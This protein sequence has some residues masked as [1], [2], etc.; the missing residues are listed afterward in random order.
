MRGRVST[1]HE[2]R[3]AWRRLKNAYAAMEE[4]EVELVAALQGVVRP[5]VESEVPPAPDAE[6]RRLHGWLRGSEARA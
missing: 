3:L 1:S 2:D 4:A 5:G 6:P